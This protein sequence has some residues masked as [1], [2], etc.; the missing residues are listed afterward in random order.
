LASSAR[1]AADTSSVAAV[2]CSVPM[3]RF[4]AHDRPSGAGGRICAVPRTETR[5]RRNGDSPSWERGLASGGVEPGDGGL[6]AGTA[7]AAVAVERPVFDGAARVGA[8]PPDPELDEL[9]VQPGAQ[10]EPRGAGARAHG[11]ARQP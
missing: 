3:D 6:A 1:R 10:V 11:A 5:R 4:S 8:D 9:V 7:V 2:V